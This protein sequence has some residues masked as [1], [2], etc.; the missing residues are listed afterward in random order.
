MTLTITPLLIK[1]SE[2]SLKHISLKALSSNLTF[3]TVINIDSHSR[4]EGV[5]LEQE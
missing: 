2:P 1:L 3:P 5:G 4:I